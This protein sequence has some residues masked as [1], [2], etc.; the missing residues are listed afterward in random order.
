MMVLDQGL[1][2]LQDSA[3]RERRL[4]IEQAALLMQ[5]RLSSH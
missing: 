1:E 4:R 5:R 2:V 3:R